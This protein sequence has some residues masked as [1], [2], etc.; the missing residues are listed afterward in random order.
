MLAKVVADVLNNCL[1]LCDYNVFFGTGG[2]DADSR[3]LSKRMV[4]L[5]FWACT[6][7]GIALVDLNVVFE[8]QLFKQPDDALAA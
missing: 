7:V 5:Q 3:R 8:V 2:S 4:G 1:A 6:L